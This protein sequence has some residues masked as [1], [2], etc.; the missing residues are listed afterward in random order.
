MKHIEKII[1]IAFAVTVLFLGA[2][3]IL[4]SDEASYASAGLN[5]IGYQTP[6]DPV[7]PV[8][9][10]FV[11]AFFF[12]VKMEFVAVHILIPLLAIAS[13][14][15]V[16]K[17]TEDVWNKKTALIALILFATSGKIMLFSG[18]FLTEMPTVFFLLF[19]FYAFR[20]KYFKISALATFLAI[21][22]RWFNAILAI[23]FIFLLLFK[24]YTKNLPSIY[25]R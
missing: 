10:P 21:T 18:Q 15:L 12:F 25:Q 7:L 1:I 11:F 3:N 5:L 9:L 8:F 2:N 19:A 14:I 17:I 24:K 20:K 22:V 13:A 4:Y 6:Y 23:P 16:Y